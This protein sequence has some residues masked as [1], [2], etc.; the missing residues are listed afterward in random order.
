MAT[1]LSETDDAPALLRRSALETEDAPFLVVFFFD[2]AF[3]NLASNA[4]G[5]FFG[6][7]FIFQDLLSLVHGEILSSA[8]EL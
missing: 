8:H 6:F 5:I 2:A 4:A 7:F 3:L 1:S